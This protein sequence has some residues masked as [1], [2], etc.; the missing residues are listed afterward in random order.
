MSDEFSEAESGEI[1]PSPQHEE[2]AADSRG[3]PG[4][5]LT[6]SPSPAPEQRNGHAVEASP[7]SQAGRTQTRYNTR[8]KGLVT[9]RSPSHPS[10]LSKS[11]R[12]RLNREAR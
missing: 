9:P 5:I 7:G 4:Q 11:Q 8:Y 10:Q 12:K 2:D 6:P 3:E 1:P